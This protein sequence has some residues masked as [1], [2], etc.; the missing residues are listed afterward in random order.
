MKLGA[1]YLLLLLCLFRSDLLIAESI[2]IE[3]FS[4]LPM[5]QQPILSPDGKYIAAILNQGDWTHVA[6]IPFDNKESTKTLLRLGVSK[7][8]IE[9]IA[10]ANNGRVIISVT[11]PLNVGR[12]NVRVRANSLF[13][14]TI[15]GE[16]F[17][18]LRK[19]DNRKNRTKSRY[20]QESPR[21]L[22]IL[23]ND[24]EHILV[25]L[26]DEHDNYFPA[27]F[28]V[29]ITT[30]KFKKYLRNSKRFIYWGVEENGEVLM[31]IG[32][33]KSHRSDTHYIYTRESAEAE[34]EPV[35][36]FETFKTETFEP[37][38]YEPEHHSI[39][40]ISDYKLEKAALWRYNIESGE[41]TLLGEAPGKFDVT[42][43]ITRLEGQQRTVVGFTYNDN[44]VQRVYFDKDN[45]NLSQK[46]SALFGKNN[47]EATLVDWDN[48]RNRFIVYAVS[49]KSPGKYYL[50][51]KESNALGFW[52]SSY[53]FL[54]S[55]PLVNVQPFDFQARDG[56]QLHGYLTLPFG[57]EHPPLIV[58]PHGGPFARDSQYFDPFVQMLASRG[59]A[60]L[61]VNFRGS[62]GYGNEYREAG[63]KEWGKKMQTD[64][65]D[66]LNWVKAS[67]LVN[68][69]QACIIGASY[70]GYAAL[71]AGYQTPELF[72]CM[73]S[74]AGTAN[75]RTSLFHW[76]RW[77][78][79]NYIDNAVTDDEWELKKMS[80][81]NH[82]AEFMAPVLLIH[83]KADTVV[84]FR[85]SEAMYKALRRA[86]KRVELQL[87]RYGTHDLDD[88]VNLKNSMS[89]IESF[90]AKHL[91]VDTIDPRDRP[92]MTSAIYP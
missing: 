58:F 29:D 40:V 89:L 32:V 42:S 48:A 8:R 83:G 49:D 71:T 43:A 75:M 21:L 20:K 12:W 80:P 34:W 54:E 15:D 69:E 73:I 50:Y 67:R 65:I 35:K 86:K 81:V 68:T 56:M 14:A 53:P 47:L 61:Q 52:Y 84:S 38:L 82:A 39:V 19:K 9:D 37:I 64:L 78:N 62:T 66:G 92:N 24:P 13:S 44:Y 87:Y 23:R 63:Y 51:E 7:Y 11:Q 57:S 2:P 70:G 26:Q 27:I 76:H 18:E 41:Y 4:H 72:K 28:K 6:I 17:F 10:W 59:Y 3:H 16:E 90:L 25:T 46:I 91:P 85:Q 74:I 33:D 30:G 45:I 60:I 77:G 88:P 22:N 5:V 31:G 55:A 1:H 79:D 36:S